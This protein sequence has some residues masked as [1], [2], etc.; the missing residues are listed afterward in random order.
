MKMDL[1]LEIYP[2][3]VIAIFAAI[4][5]IVA[6]LSITKIK[7]SEQKNKQKVE[8]VNSN[9]NRGDQKRSSKVDVH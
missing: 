4:A 8:E 7:I 6:I 2:S 5:V 3:V 1:F 9:D